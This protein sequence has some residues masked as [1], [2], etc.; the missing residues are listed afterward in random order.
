MLGDLSVST[1]E[2]WYV[3]HSMLI[4]I[5]TPSLGSID[6]L[7]QAFLNT[8]SFALQGV[9]LGAITGF[10]LSLVFQYRIIRI[11]SAFIRSIHELFWALIFIQIFGLTPL[12]GVLAIAIPYAGTFARVYFELIDDTDSAPLQGIPKS[13]SKLSSWLYGRLTQAWPHIIIYS[14]YRT[15]CAIRSSAVLGF[16]GLPTIGF[17]L[18]TAFRQGNYSEA[19]GLLYAFI[20]VIA[21]LRWWLKA[22]LLPFYLI[23]SILWLPPVTHIDSTTLLRFLTVDIVPAPLRHS[24]SFTTIDTNYLSLWIEQVLY[25]SALPGIIQ[26][27]G[28]GLIALA[29]TGII[30]LLLFPLASKLFLKQPLHG[31]GQLFLIVARTIPEYVLAFIALLMLG[32]SW[33]PA[34]IALS[35]HN[36]SIIAYL[37]GQISNSIVLRQDACSGLNRYCYEVIPRIYRQFLSLL[38]YRW[39][40]ILRETAILGVLGIHTLG[41]YIDSAFEALRLDQAFA[42]IIIAA[43]LNIT[44]D[45]LALTIRNRL[46]L[47]NTP[48]EL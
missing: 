12:T 21:T 17:H 41:F 26:T 46:K 44:A 15:E 33:I 45:Q 13:T 37:V 9:A 11:L 20:L 14:R 4:G 8:L 29:V 5:A 27:L 42:L 30:A 10:G 16:I 24:E 28:I 22:P 19:A 2:P 43:M 47:T 36:G 3:L 39:E 48:E 18:E 6:T 40:I 32:P 7:F 23:A 1:G 34:I 35:L 31:C 25:Q 38:F